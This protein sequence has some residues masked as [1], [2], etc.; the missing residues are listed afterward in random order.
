MGK[1]KKRLIKKGQIQAGKEPY[2]QLTLNCLTPESQIKPRKTENLLPS[3]CVKASSMQNNQI[4]ITRIGSLLEEDE[5]TLEVEFKLLPSKSTFSKI[6]SDLW[7]D[8]QKISSISIGVP[9]RFGPTNEF[10]LNPVL[11]LK[12]ISS[13]F[14][15]AKIEMYEVGPTGEKR[16]CNMKEVAVE[17]VPQSR[18][19]RLKK[20]PTVKK[21]AGLEIAVVLESEKGIY[22]EIEEAKRKELISNRDEW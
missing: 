6:R 22:R 1:R 3:T 7:F 8:E 4:I 14:H 2:R 20:V 21:I 16:A 12:G 13:G 5:L 18:E 15:I 9:Q 19:T 11:D 10:Q 17:Y